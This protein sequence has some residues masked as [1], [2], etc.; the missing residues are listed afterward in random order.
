MSY[1]LTYDWN[2][3]RP[4]RRVRVQDATLAEGVL[5][6]RVGPLNFED[7]RAFVEQST[8]LDLDSVDLGWVLD[9]PSLDRVRYLL[10]GFRGQRASCSI[11]A[12]LGLLRSLASRMADL[13]IELD[14]M[15]SH[16]KGNHQAA[17]NACRK[18]RELG[19]RPF[20]TVVGGDQIKPAHLA[21]LLTSA[22]R[23]E[24]VGIL[25]HDATGRLPDLAIGNLLG[26]ARRA[27]DQVA[28]P[29]LLGWS[30][31]DPYGLALA[32]ALRA[33]AE[34]ADF[35]RA[36]SLGLG[37][38]GFTPLELVLVNL[39]LDGY[40]SEPLWELGPYVKLASERLGYCVPGDYP[41]FGTD[42]FRTATGVHAAA[43]AKAP[44]VDLAD[45]VYSSVPASWVGARQSIEVGP[46]SGRW[47]VMHWLK[48]RRIDEP[49]T[50]AVDRIL[51]AAKTRERVLTEL[52]VFELLRAVG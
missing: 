4:E 34:G 50:A 12:D 49:E 38:E 28:H 47:N 26:T 19:L 20:L 30:S 35:V 21:S 52:E 43:V 24:C 29:P 46:M 3:A 25:F 41:V 2:A 36:S 40:R 5:D 6:S 37:R 48:Q 51:A 27:L 32:G 31:S 18:A 33:V 1:D 44:T 10:Q 15:I 45:R 17:L 14:V 22:M 11:P 23:A 42:A 8:R 39:K 7:T 9:G 13:P 16:P